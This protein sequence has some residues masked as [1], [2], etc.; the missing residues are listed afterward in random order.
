MVQRLPW[1]LRQAAHAQSRW[2][3]QQQTRKMK[4]QVRTKETEAPPTHNQK[5]LKEGVSSPDVLTAHTDADGALG[6]D[7][8]TAVAVAGYHLA[9][10]P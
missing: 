4:V 10:T 1:F 5:Q 8:G 9:H 7:A 3:S 6:L 2:G